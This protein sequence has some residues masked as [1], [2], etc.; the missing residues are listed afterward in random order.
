VLRAQVRQSVLAKGRQDVAVR[1]CPVAPERRRFQ[2]FQLGLADP[3]LD[4]FGDRSQPDRDLPVVGLR[5]Q[6]GQRGVGF[7]GGA[8][9][10][11]RL[12]LAPAGQWVPPGVDA[13]LP[14]AGPTALAL[15]SSHR[16][17][18]CPTDR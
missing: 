9:E 17:L 13:Q 15:A 1:R 7:A 12:L 4:G 18:P 8:L 5:H 14:G 2:A 16:V 11:D 6:L 3:G 10:D